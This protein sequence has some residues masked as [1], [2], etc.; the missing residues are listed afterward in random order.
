M[1]I[2]VFCLIVW[3]VRMYNT[4]VA[5]TCDN[6]VAVDGGGVDKDWDVEEG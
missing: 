5:K 3:W 1:L 2:S 6:Y 4:G